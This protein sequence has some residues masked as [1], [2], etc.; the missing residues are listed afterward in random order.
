LAQLYQ[1]AI[2]ALF[3]VGDV[4][5][6]VDRPHTCMDGDQQARGNGRQK[7]LYL[8]LGS[9]GLLAGATALSVGLTAGHVHGSASA[10]TR[11][12]MAPTSTAPPDIAIADDLSLLK[13]N[14]VA[15]KAVADGHL[16]ITPKALSSDYKGSSVGDSIVQITTTAPTYPL[17]AQYA[18][19]LARG[20]LTV[21]ASVQGSALQLQISQYQDDLNVLNTQISNLTNQIGA[22]TPASPAQPSAQ[23][24]SQIQNLTNLRASDIQQQNTVTTELNS[25]QANLNALTDGNVIVDPAMPP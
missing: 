25:E 23:A 11:I 13:T 10:V 17:A 16:D 24:A 15:A 20:F 19:A 6:G 2:W 12:N 5:F 18:N 8:V 4:F 14:Q 21:Q 7:G 22:L 1:R 3:Q 9:L